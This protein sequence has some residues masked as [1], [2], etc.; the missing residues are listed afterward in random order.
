[1]AINGTTGDD[2]LNGTALND[3]INGLGGLDI[4]NGGAGN[5]TLDG[6]ADND[7]LNGGLGNNTY[8]FGKGSGQDSLASYYDTT[9]GKL[10]TLQFKA[11]VLVS[12]V[13]ATRTG[14]DLLLTVSATDSVL[15]QDFFYTDNPANS[16]NPLQQIKFADGTIW[17]LSTITAKAFIGTA[18]ADTMFGTINND[19]LTGAAGIDILNGNAGNDTLDGGIDNDTLN[20]GAGNNTYL[21]GKGDGQDSIASYYNTTL[22]KL[23][24]LQFKAGVLVSDVKATRTGNDLLLTVSATDSV[25][26]QD[27]FYT[28]NPANSYNPL[29]QIK[30]A[31]GTIWNLSTI[32][33]KAFI[34]TAQA[35]TMF[36]TINNDVLTGAAGID[37][38]NGNA[39]NDTIDGGIDNDTLNGGSGNNTYLFGK[40]DGQDS[41]A[42]Y[43]DTT[44]G[45]SNTLQF[46]ANVI[47]SDV[48]AYRSGTN[49]VLTVSATDSLTVA[50]FFYTDNP[51]NVYNPLQQLKFADG[52]IWNL[53]TIAAKA[54]IGT[55]SADTMFGTIN[56][57]VLTGAAGIDILNGNA[58]NDTIDGGIDNDTLNGGGGNNTYLFGKGDGQDVLTNFYDGTLGKL[59]TLQ[60][61]AGVLVSDVAASQS[62]SNLVLT[63][64]ATDSVTIQDFFYT[65]NPTNIYNPLQQIKFADGTLWNISTIV[66]RTLTGATFTGTAGDDVLVGTL[67]NDHFFGGLG[68]DIYF[69]NTIGDT[70]TEGSALPGEIDTVNSSVNFVLGANLE[71]LNL[72][73]A[74]VINGTGNGLSNV[75]IG[76]KAANTLNGGAG[77]DVMMGGLGNDAY[78][79]DNISDIVIETSALATEIDTAYSL[80]SYAL[81]NNL[82][83]LVLTGAAVSN[84]TGNGLNNVMTGNAAANSLN[85]G[86]GVDV[87]IGGLGKDSLTGGLGIDQFKFNVN[88]ETGIT[89]ATSDV[90]TDFSHAQGDKINL[91]AIDANSV[92]AGDNSFTAITVGGAFSGSF[93]N[94]G[95]LY[96][97]QIAH[98]LY[99]NNDADSAADFSIQLTGVIN[100]VVADFVL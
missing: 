69:V 14:N 53:S 7:T 9:L 72:T 86:A 98:I 88:A 85:G 50:D 92:L 81:G 79:I 90:I 52:T 31:D 49:L 75:L 36:G 80:I 61:K 73:G 66:S 63:I 13:K 45:K 57:D 30:F 41:L 68:N 42:S 24:T 94:Q 76:N 77:S 22:G 23:N 4:L 91:V 78:V 87:L 84:A 44:F 70:V 17:N 35:D 32:T 2:T 3:I 40:G 39:G 43:Y 46:K 47:V 54:F 18:Q 12:D 95:L 99:G 56:N 96:F 60:F 20:G 29:Q 15:V 1:M 74:A 65:N 48:K 8:L 27:F 16:Y 25:L 93:A 11:G 89:L 97:D 38:L 100:L 62:G 33:A 6:G 10:N 37:I 34:G 21:F 51:A 26:V 67:Q 59:N 71:N 28:D 55:A 19:V 82:E 64:S 5:D 58:G 83:N